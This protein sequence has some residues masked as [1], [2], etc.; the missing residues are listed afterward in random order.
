M[1]DNRE[2]FDFSEYFHLLWIIM[3]F[4]FYVY[5]V[6]YWCYKWFE[7]I[8]KY[9]NKIIC[10]C[11]LR[12]PSKYKILFFFS[13]SA[14]QHLEEWVRLFDLF[15]NLSFDVPNKCWCQWKNGDKINCIWS[16]WLKR[17][18]LAGWNEKA[19]NTRTEYLLNN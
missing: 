17:S 18:N 16:G 6:F 9:E 8:N 14:F 10:V 12:P 7:A 15:L 11:V 1:P 19:S 13:S 2:Y 5:R 3:L 4:H